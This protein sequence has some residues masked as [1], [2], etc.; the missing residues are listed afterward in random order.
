MA[1]PS[2]PARQFLSPERFPNVQFDP[3]CHLW[4]DVEEFEALAARSEAASL[5]PATALYR[6]DFL[7]GFYDD[8]I[9]SERY[10]LESLYLET[11]ARLIAVY[12][13]GK[14]DQAALAM[15]LRLLDR[16][17]LREEAHQAAMRAYCGLGQRKAALLQ[18]RRCLE[19]LR[20]ELDVEPTVETQNLYQAI[21]Q[22][23]FIVEP[24]H[25][26]PS[27]EFLPVGTAATVPAGHDPLDV[28]A[29][30][31]LAGRAQETSFLED[32]WRTVQEKGSR[33]TLVGGEAGVGKTRLVEEFANHLR[34]QGIR[35]LWGRCYEFEHAL[36]Y[37][38][39]ADALRTCL[40]L[41][42]QMN[43]PVFLP[44]RCA[45]SPALCQNCWNAF[46]RRK[47]RSRVIVRMPRNPGPRSQPYPAW[48]RSKRV[49]LEA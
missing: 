36:P 28:T 13:A 5:H 19:I 2:L 31:K 18:Y 16:D 37:Q 43:W 49:S 1:Y 10:R 42:P 44:G 47:R 25:D 38:P 48:I 21:L 12:E 22:G 32:C 9:I 4:L 33:L 29:T 24:A 7:D 30:V 35:V 6:G 40:P 17:P 23:S 34:W 11:L 20:K 15:A 8:W 27:S 3:D 46:P 14:D 45:R 39:V 26:I 41:L